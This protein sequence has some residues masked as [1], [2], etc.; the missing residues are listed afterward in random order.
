MSSRND[1]VIVGRKSTMNYVV[2]CI[3]LF[4]SG[5]DDIKI[6][7]RGR[8]ISRA[9]ETVEMLK[10]GFIKELKIKNI[11]IGSQEYEKQGKIRNISTIEMTLA[12]PVKT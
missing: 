2:A 1:A 9:I 6:K 10:R 3:T 7:A 5:I 4:N 8:S 12:K 11:T